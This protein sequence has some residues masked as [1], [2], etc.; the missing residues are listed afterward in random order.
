MTS[1]VAE[2]CFLMPWETKSNSFHIMNFFSFFY[3][4]NRIESLL[5][6]LL[7]LKAPPKLPC[8]DSLK[9]SFDSLHTLLYLICIILC[10][11]KIVFIL[12]SSLPYFQKRKSCNH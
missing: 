2:S 8:A 6:L 10:K 11:K 4:F 12:N 1:K 3:L 9:V 7:L 5:L